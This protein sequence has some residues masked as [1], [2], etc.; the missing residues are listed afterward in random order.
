[1]EKLSPEKVVTQLGSY[2]AKNGTQDFWLPCMSFPDQRPSGNC[3]TQVLSGMPLSPGLWNKGP[4]A[5]FLRLQLQ[6]PLRS[7]CEAAVTEEGAQA[8]LAA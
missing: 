2:S 7:H 1:M 3:E 4:T 6:D 5:S 8:Q